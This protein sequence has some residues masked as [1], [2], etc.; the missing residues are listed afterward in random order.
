MTTTK[1]AE[2]RSHRHGR[3]QAELLDALENYVASQAVTDL[4]GTLRAAEFNDGY[5][6]AALLAGAKTLI[7]SLPH[8]A[9]FAALLAQMAA[10]AEHGR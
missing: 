3:Q 4:V 9:P 1:R 2:A 5:I 8:K 6:A 10:E 7:R